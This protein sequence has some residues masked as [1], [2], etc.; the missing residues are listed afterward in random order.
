MLSIV[1]FSFTVTEIIS[2]QTI[3][4]TIMEP[5][6]NATFECQLDSEP[7]VPCKQLKSF[8]GSVLTYLLCHR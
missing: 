5:S 1:D 3:T 7:F 8:T 4:L 6:G 2:E